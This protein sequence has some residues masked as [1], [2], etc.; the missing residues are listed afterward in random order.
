MV[1]QNIMEVGVYSWW[2]QKTKR[3]DWEAGIT[4]RGIAV[5]T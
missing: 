3:R 4:F 2:Q 5:V 1:R